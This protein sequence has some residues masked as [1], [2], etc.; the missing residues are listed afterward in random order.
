MEGQMKLKHLIAKSKLAVAVLGLCASIP[1]A[2]ADTLLIQPD[3]ELRIPDGSTITSVNIVV[4][5]GLDAPESYAL[6]DFTFAGGYGTDTAF[7]D[8][9]GNTGNIIFTSPAV[10]LTFE[11]V[12]GSAFYASVFGENGLIGNVGFSAETTASGNASFTVPVT[13]INWTSG[14]GSGGG[15]NSMSYTVV[16]EPGTPLLVGLG[17]ILVSGLSLKNSST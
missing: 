2:H 11:F 1:S 4:P 6:V 12:G 14:Y 3:Y 7:A 8:A 13:S 10:D 15:I 17:L 16:P 9:D 5:P